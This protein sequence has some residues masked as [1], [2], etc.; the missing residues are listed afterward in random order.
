MKDNNNDKKGII[1]NAA[2]IALLPTVSAGFLTL[3]FSAIYPETLS[4]PNEACIR[5][6]TATFFSLAAVSVISST[7]KEVSDY[8][9]EPQQDNL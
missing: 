7:L 2:K 6:T 5:V 3:L 4:N 1:F 8:L 9:L